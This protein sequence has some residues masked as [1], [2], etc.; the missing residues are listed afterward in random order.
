RFL[1]RAPASTEVDLWSHALEAGLTDEQLQ[2]QFVTSGEYTARQAQHGRDRLSG[3]YQDLLGRTPDAVG[4]AAWNDAL[5]H[6][7]SQ[8]TVA[9]A[10]LNSAEAQTRLVTD[11]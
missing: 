1:E 10:I 5:Q 4:L 3:L 6:G 9:L 2:V 7:A 8:S 11:V